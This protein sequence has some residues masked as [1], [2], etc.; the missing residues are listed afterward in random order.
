MDF[1]YLYMGIVEDF[2]SAATARAVRLSHPVLRTMLKAAPAT[3]SFLN[4]IFG[5]ISPSLKITIVI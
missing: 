2:N 3:V 4:L 5:A 1:I